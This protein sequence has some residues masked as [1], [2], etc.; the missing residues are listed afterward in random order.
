MICVVYIYTGATDVN[1]FQITMNFHSLNTSNIYGWTHN[2]VKIVYYD[3]FHMLF[4]QPSYKLF[5]RRC[6]S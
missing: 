4:L 5:E 6:A 2:L 1:I 3:L